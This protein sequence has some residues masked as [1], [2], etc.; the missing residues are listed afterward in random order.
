MFRQVSKY[1]DKPW[2]GGTTVGGGA[3]GA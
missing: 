2:G 3:G 1:F